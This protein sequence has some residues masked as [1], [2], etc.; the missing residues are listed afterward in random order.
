MKRVSTN[1]ELVSIQRIRANLWG[2]VVECRGLKK[3]ISGVRVKF[4]SGYTRMFRSLF[5]ALLLMFLIATLIGIVW[6]APLPHGLGSIDF[7]P[8]WSAAYLLAQG[9]DFCDLNQIDAVERALTG[10]R[11]D[12]PMQAW[13]FPT[14]HLILL[15]LT[16]L[17]F[18]QAV[19]VWLLI[20]IGI[21]FVCSLLLW[22]N[23]YIYRW[24]PLLVTFSYSMTL[25]S[26]YFGQVNSLVLLGLALFL[27]LEERQKPFLAGLALILTTVKPHLVIFTL[28]MLLL[29]GFQQREWLRLSG[30]FLA[31]LSS[32]LL[33]FFLYP[34]WLRSL[35]HLA[36][37]GFNSL[38]LTPTLAGLLVVLGE[39]HLSRWLWL[40]GL[41][42]FL[43]LRLVLK[44]VD[45]RTFVDLTLLGGMVLSPLGWSYDQILLLIP[46][47]RLM[48]WC[49]QKELPSPF[50]GQMFLSLVV[51]NLLTCLQRIFI[52][53][54]VWFFW[55][56]FALAFF[57]Y[58]SWQRR[59]S[60]CEAHPY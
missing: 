60:S 55:L 27:Y 22:R 6:R 1:R 47:F 21:L 33:L 12:Y 30:F 38:R 37:S 5:S 17:P 3:Q 52:H 23:K 19:K 9:K 41:G 50:A 42:I 26:L 16:F 59:I 7:R 39:T 28:P 10:W 18:Q 11:E 13:F 15:P 24:L 25:V 2:F 49:I 32:F 54:D 35:V 36:F 58:L 48:E 46:V 8:Y 43:A 56:P 51:L 4:V 45:L 53:N 40:G 29:D 34:D 57:Y 14:G 31:L 20:H 44:S